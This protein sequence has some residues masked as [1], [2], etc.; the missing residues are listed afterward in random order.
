MSLTKDKGTARAKTNG[1][2]DPNRGRY[3]LNNR[4]RPIYYS[5][6]S[7]AAFQGCNAFWWFQ[8]VMG[9]KEPE[10]PALAYGN[11][12]HLWLETYLEFGTELEP[13]TYKD[14]RGGAIE[15]TSEHIIR[16][17][18]SLPL[19]PAVGEGNVEMW[20]SRVPVYD[21]DDGLMLFTGKIDW[22]A[23]FGVPWYPKG[24][25]IPRWFEGMHV[26]DHKTKGHATGRY[27][28]PSSED[29]ARNHQGQ[30][31]AHVVTVDTPFEGTDVLF[32]HNYVVKKGRPR[33]VRVDTTMKSE[34]IQATWEAQAEPARQMILASKHDRVDDIPTNRGHCNAFGRECPF[35]RICP[36]HNRPATSLLN[37]LAAFDGDGDETTDDQEHTRM[38]TNFLDYLDDEP[39]PA[40]P[41]PAPPSAAP[42]PTPLDTKAQLLTMGYDGGQIV[43]MT[44]ITAAHIVSEGL[45]AEGIS[46]TKDG[47]IR[48]VK[49]AP[50]AVEPSTEG[51]PAPPA[52]MPVQP[53]DTKPHDNDQVSAA[54]IDEAVDVVA[55][56]YNQQLAAG[57]EPKW[58]LVTVGT[59]IR[60]EGLH[61]DWAMNV[62]IL[63][64]LD[65][66]EADA[67]TAA[68]EA[69]TEEQLYSAPY[70][71]L[72]ASGD[73]GASNTDR[74]KALAA[75]PIAAFRDIAGETPRDVLLAARTIVSPKQRQ[76]IDELLDDGRL[77]T[78]FDNHVD[79]VKAPGERDALRALWIEEQSGVELTDEVIDQTLK[80]KKV[81]KRK[82][83]TRIKRIRELLAAPPEVPETAA[84][85][86]PETPVTMTPENETPPPV[87]ALLDSDDLRTFPAVLADAL[88]EPRLAP[89]LLSLMAVYAARV[90][91]EAQDVESNTVDALRAAEREI[92]TLKVH[93]KVADDALQE[94][95]DESARL[96]VDATP[97]P[98][99]TTLFAGCRPLNGAV[100]HIDTFL[101]K[102]GE[103][104]LRKVNM[105]PKHAEVDH[106]TLGE[107]GSG[108]R[109]F[110]NELRA[111]LAANGAP[112]G[113]FYFARNSV[114]KDIPLVELFEA[115]GATVVAG[116]YG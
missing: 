14:D 69:F 109:I 3:A 16:S 48:F 2:D 83:P 61:R 93:L 103:R 112:E 25:D 68:K 1:P 63:A 113:Q 107:F 76:I 82:T 70:V 30:L 36:A 20:A 45:R 88:E 73:N 31:Y 105:Q 10:G 96:T 114:Y 87:Q 79:D 75:T 34:D 92:N 50:Q 33:A 39:E 4:G 13:G 7:A 12:V 55:R 22:H 52:V 85:P 111:E 24:P 41:A 104:A 71:S 57:G 51:D 17:R 11:A 47:D 115:A 9:E 43:R 46:I 98:A 106:W 23:E 15:L 91:P 65:I 19:L 64:G 80:A 110:T 56:T 99:G 86:V 108:P 35:K 21:G 77:V 32:S 67:L 54:L 116:A 28:I 97:Q 49:A 44:D 62:A 90:A 78:P 95:H 29:L 38:G 84:T 59:M 37:A 8:K 53:D 58:S 89:H 5:P 102:I 42:S 60:R 66:I 81:Y 6:S 27:G 26:L 101:A 74:A 40:Q 94:A 72:T 100:P 18:T